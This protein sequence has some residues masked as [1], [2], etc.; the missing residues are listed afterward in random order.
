MFRHYVY[1]AHHLPFCGMA[2]LFSASDRGVAFVRESGCARIAVSSADV[3]Q[4]AVIMAHEL[5]HT[6][7]LVHTKDD[8]GVMSVGA[9]GVTFSATQVEQARRVARTGRGWLRGASGSPGGG[10]RWRWR[11]RRLSSDL[12]LKNDSGAFSYSGQSALAAAPIPLFA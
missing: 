12:T 9:A 8:C 1:I 5:G 3:D 7:S 2:P 11:R 10:W 6:L 4:V